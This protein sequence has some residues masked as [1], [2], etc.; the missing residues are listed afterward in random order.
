MRQEETIGYTKAICPHCNKGVPI[1]WDRKCC[2][3]CGLT[4]R[5][6]IREGRGT[7]IQWYRYFW[8]DDGFIQ[9]YKWRK[10]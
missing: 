6:K 2:T 4:Y 8:N 1:G 3:I 10:L 9:I 7:N 5:T